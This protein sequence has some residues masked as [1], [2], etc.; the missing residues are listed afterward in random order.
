MLVNNGKDSQMV[1]KYE[2]N[3]LYDLFMSLS[4]CLLSSYTTVCLL[5]VLVLYPMKK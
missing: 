5:A 2:G 1:L 3:L 4:L